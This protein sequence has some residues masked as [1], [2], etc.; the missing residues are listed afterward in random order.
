MDAVQL[1]KGMNI[2]D[3]SAGLPRLHQGV[4]SSLSHRVLKQGT[5]TFRRKLMVG[6]V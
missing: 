5:K 1:V 6:T 2:A 3:V 4:H